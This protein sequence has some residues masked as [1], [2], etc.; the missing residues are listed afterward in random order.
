M[1]KQR[2]HVGAI[3][4]SP[5]R[6]MEGFL[7]LGARYSNGIQTGIGHRSERIPRGFYY[8][9]K[10]PSYHIVIILVVEDCYAVPCRDYTPWK[11]ASTLHLTGRKYRNR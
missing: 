8:S 5:A 10:R 1:K 7:N 4:Q 11:I 3:F 2:L 9:I 6:R